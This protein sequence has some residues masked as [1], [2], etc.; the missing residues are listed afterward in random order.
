V[1]RNGLGWAQTSSSAVLANPVDPNAPVKKEGDGRSPA[2]IFPLTSSFGYAAQPQ[3][4]LKLPYIALTPT[5]ECVDDTASSFYNRIVNR[6]TL[7][8]DWHSSEQMASAGEAYRWGAVID[9]NPSGLRGA[10]S[11]VFLHIWAG[12]GVGTSGCTAM[13]ENQL[14]D[15]LVWL[16]PSRKPVIVELPRDQYKK[17]RKHLHLPKP[18]KA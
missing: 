15:I 7:T 14:I 8:P 11:C 5:V 9:F 12:Q 17:I 18:P 2:G 10:G 16:D 13:P 4:G 3:P 1:G 6:A